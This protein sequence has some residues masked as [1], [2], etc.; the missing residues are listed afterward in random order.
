MAAMRLCQR[1]VQEMLEL[2]RMYRRLPD[3][4][5]CR[6]GAAGIAG[7]TMFGADLIEHPFQEDIDEHPTAH[8]ARFFLTPDDFGLLEARELH[9]QRLGRKRV[10]LLDAEQVDVVD[11]ALFALL[12]EVVIDLAGAYDDAANL[13]V[14]NELDFFA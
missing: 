3:R 1:L 14:G 4:G 5:R 6:G 7:A 2:R 11:A 12:I 13:I 10:E 8:I 9:H